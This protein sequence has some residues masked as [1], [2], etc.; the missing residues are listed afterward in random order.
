MFLVMQLWR[1]LAYKCDLF[2]SAVDLATNKSKVASRPS[3]LC[4]LY[5]ILVGPNRYVMCVLCSLLCFVPAEIP[6]PHFTLMENRV[7][8]EVKVKVK[9]RIN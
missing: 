1:F 2:Y 7:F 8:E 6:Y 9:A 5:N 3:C 4:V